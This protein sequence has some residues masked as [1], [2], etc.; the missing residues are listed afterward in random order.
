MV[1]LFV[2]K[3]SAH[4][5]RFPAALKLHFIAPHASGQKWRSFVGQLRKVEF[6]QH[7]ASLVFIAAAL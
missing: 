2:F 3:Y 4:L 6:N 1:C 7:Q 5:W